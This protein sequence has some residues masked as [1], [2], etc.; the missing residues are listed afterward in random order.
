MPQA[1]TIQSLPRAFEFVKAM[2]AEGLEWG[3]GYRDLG[4]EA[5]A[6]ILQSQMAQAIDD[7]LDRM[8]LLDEAD[9]RNSSYRRHL[10]TELGDIELAVPR[11]RRF[12]PIA[13]VRAYARRPEQV[14]RMILSCFVL[15]LSV[16]KVS[17]ALLPILGRPISPATV[18]AVAKQLDA[19]VAAFHARPLKDQYRVLMLDGVVLARRTGAGSSSWSPSDCGMTARR[20][21]STSAWRRA[22]APPN[23][24]A[25]LVTSSAAASLARGSR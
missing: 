7:H 23:G 2:Q 5:I 14:D 11:T 13:V 19:V 3:E 18:S 22:R 9:R 24:S 25:F 6:A 16:R 21:S 10:L 1:V 8:V 15:G 20:R 17:Q 12:A 4:R